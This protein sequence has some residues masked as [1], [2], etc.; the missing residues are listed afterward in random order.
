[1]ELQAIRLPAPGDVVGDYRI[2]GLIGDGGQGR[3]YRAEAFGK[4]YALKFIE[5][6]F[7]RWG[8]REVHALLALKPLEH[9]GVVR[10]IAC[11]RWPDLDRGIFYVVMEY[12]EG[13]TLHD[14]VMVHNPS[15]RKAGQLVLSLGRT[16]LAVQEAGV[17]HRDVKPENIMVRLPGEEPVVLDFGL[18]ALVGARSSAG[19]GQ[20]TGTL[21]YLSPEAWRHAR[22]EEGR[23]RPTPRD[24]QW[25]LGVTFYWLLTDRLPF[26]ARGSPHDATGASGDPEGAPRHQ[27]PRT[28]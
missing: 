21:E 12:V 2:L 4:S 16:L 5:R 23:Y 18:A 14:Y 13:L 8:E 27:P 15:A 7:D 9:P 24:E 17:L 20:V 25:A 6:G 28:A 22:D 19:A 11:G 1:M 10:F 3:V 26:G